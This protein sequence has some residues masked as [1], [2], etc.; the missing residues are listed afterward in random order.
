[1]S[2]TRRAKQADG[3]CRLPDGQNVA[4]ALSDANARSRRPGSAA[5]L[6]GSPGRL[7]RCQT[8]SHQRLRVRHSREAPTDDEKIAKSLRNILEFFAGKE[9][10]GQR[11]RVRC[12][13][14]HPLPDGVLKIMMR[15]ADKQDEVA[16]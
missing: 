2:L 5:R 13:T 10:E 14:Q 8:S 15:G 12:A 6:I 1:M 16:A 7:A 11:R 4:P 9:G 3:F